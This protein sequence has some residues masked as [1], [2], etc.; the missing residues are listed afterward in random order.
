MESKATRKQIRERVRA[1]LKSAYPEDEG[2]EFNLETKWKDYK[3][4]FVVE[5][6]EGNR[7][8]RNI[9]K[10]SYQCSSLERNARTLNMAARKMAGRYVKI[11]DKTLYAPKNWEWPDQDDPS[12]KVQEIQGLSCKE[13][14]PFWSD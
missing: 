10:I 5:R 2:W 9:Y 14:A 13:G 3:V 7:R 1:M 11:V 4:D 6:R 8:F 12:I